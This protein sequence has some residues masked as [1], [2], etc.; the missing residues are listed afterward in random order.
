MQGRGDRCNAAPVPQLAQCAQLTQFHKDKL[1]HT[2]RIWS[3]VLTHGRREDE[4]VLSYLTRSRVDLALL[5]VAGSW[6][7][8]YLVAKEL[9]APNTVVA[10]LAARMLLA[11][12]IMFVII[13]TRQK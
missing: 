5:L 1:I 7:S 11:A 6:G 10:L 12:A 2:A 9:V 8:T 4:P 3:L 13:A